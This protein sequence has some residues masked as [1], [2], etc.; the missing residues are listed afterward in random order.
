M[1]TP[2]KTIQTA[3]LSLQNLA[4]NTVA[5]SSVLDVSTIFAAEIL[6][7]FG[8]RTTSALTAGVNFRVEGSAKASGDGHWFP[9]AIV[10][11]D[12]AAASS[13]AVNGTVNSGT[14]VITFTSTSFAS[15]QG[16]I[17]LDNSTIANSEWGRVKA[18]SANVSVTIE[19][20]LVNAQTGSTA[21]SNA[22]ILSILVDLAA[23]KR[24]RVVA[25]GSNTGQAC[26]VEVECITLDSIS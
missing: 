18:I 13:Q 23:I 17:Y 24:L 10:T 6:V 20:N 7:H 15:L 25:D 26:A 5:I 1:A 11:T 16:V 8:R 19:D 3:L 21:Y 14:N 9:L 2:N 4:S 12:T 22:Q